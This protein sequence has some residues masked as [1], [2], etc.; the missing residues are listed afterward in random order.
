M[1]APGKKFAD[2][3]KRMIKKS[4]PAEIARYD[5]LMAQVCKGYE[6]TDKETSFLDKLRF[7]LLTLGARLALDNARGG[8]QILFESMLQ[9]LVRKYHISTEVKDGQE[10]FFVLLD[11]YPGSI[12]PD[13]DTPTPRDAMVGLGMESCGFSNNLAFEVFRRPA[14]ECCEGVTSEVLKEELR[15]EK[16]Y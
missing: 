9:N 1:N 7:E 11:R 10:L 14:Q 5:E 2:K 3:A 12:N 4:R 16:S 6:P 13:R 8:R 15:N